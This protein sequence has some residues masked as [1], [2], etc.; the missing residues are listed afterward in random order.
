MDQGKTRTE[1]FFGLNVPEEV[2]GVPT[3]I[4]D[5]RA[6]WS[7]KDAYDRQA[8]HLASLFRENFLKF[9]SRV[10]PEIKAAGPSS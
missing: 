4:L 8:E 7:D 6:T 9:E 1:P 5:P 3:G 2:P 10:D